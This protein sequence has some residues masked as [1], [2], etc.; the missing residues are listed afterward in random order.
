MAE[1]F[2]MR[3]DFKSHFFLLGGCLLF[4][5]LFKLS[6]SYCF[7]RIIDFLFNSIDHNLE[8]LDEEKRFRF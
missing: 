2:R 7:A 1:I 6:D 5:M 8:E 4:D 3:Y